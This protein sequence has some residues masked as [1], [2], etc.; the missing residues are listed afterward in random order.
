M[1]EDPKDRE[2]AVP[3]SEGD[4]KVSAGAKP[5]DAPSN[6]TADSF[7]RAA[8]E[9]SVPSPSEA[10]GYAAGG[11]GAE[12]VA[13]E[14]VA[15]RYRLDR[16]LGRGGMGVVWEATHLVTRRRLAIKFVMGAHQRVDRAAAV[17][18]AP[19]APPITRTWSM[20]STSSSS[21]TERP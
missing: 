11:A 17:K 10:A 3:P 1:A 5:G 14:V 21:T 16:E 13:G 7:L 4:V 9:I 15:K 6:T 2:Q 19:R 8:A 20:C 12:F 18:P